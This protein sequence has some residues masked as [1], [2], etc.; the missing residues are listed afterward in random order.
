M[1]DDLLGR[2]EVATH[3]PEPVLEHGLGGGKVKVDDALRRVDFDLVQG[4]LGANQDGVPVV[5][6]AGRL[7]C[8]LDGTCP[9][10]LAGLDFQR[11]YVLVDQERVGEVHAD[12]RLV[13]SV[14]LVPGVGEDDNVLAERG[15]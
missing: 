14:R 10:A 7:C 5:G 9:L 8:F 2:A 6:L 3:E 4:Q 13:Q 11:V 1:L 12:Q 15:P